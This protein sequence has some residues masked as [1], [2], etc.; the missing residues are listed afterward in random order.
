MGPARMSLTPAFSGLR[1]E[2]LWRKETGLWSQG[3]GLYPLLHSSFK[4]PALPEDCLRLW[5]AIYHI[6]PT[7]CFS[8]PPPFSSKLTRL[9]VHLC[10]GH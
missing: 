3:G 6:P 8:L 1:G 9:L 4:G 7:P 10:F 5:F 2:G